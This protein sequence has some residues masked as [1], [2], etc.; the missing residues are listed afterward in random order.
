[1]R[2]CLQSTMPTER[3][4]LSLG[5]GKVVNKMFTL[6]INQYH[7]NYYYF[8]VLESYIR[9][10]T[11]INYILPPHCC[12][13]LVQTKWTGGLRLWMQLVK[14]IFLLLSKTCS[15]LWIVVFITVDIN[16]L[17]LNIWSLGIMLKPITWIC[18]F[19]NG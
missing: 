13:W 15:L 6:T 3:A 1:M 16:T 19:C 4:E 14:I 7:F 12:Q 18:N 11:E 17:W 2:M 9:N 10:G 8:C 5:Y